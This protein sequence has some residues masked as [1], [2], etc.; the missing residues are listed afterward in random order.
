MEGRLVYANNNDNWEHQ[1]VTQN[2][3]VQPLLTD[4]YQITMAYA[5]WKS[6]KT[7]DTAVFDLFFRQNPFQGEFTIFAGLDECLKF[8]QNF[9]YSNSDIAYLKATLPPSIE[10]EFFVF[11]QRLNVNDVTVYAIEEGSVAFPKVPLMR[12]EGP[13][14]IVQLLETTLLT[15]VNYASLMATNAAR[16]RM[17]AGKNVSL[18][19]FGL[20]RAQG[21]DG[22][23]SASKYAYVGGFDGT[24]N[25]LAG[26]MY[27]IPVKGTHAHAYITSFSDIGDL[28]HKVAKTQKSNLIDDLS[29]MMSV[30]RIVHWTDLS[31]SDHMLVDRNTGQER[32]L[33]ALS[34]EWRGKI[35]GLLDTLVDAAS[36]G[37][38]AALI[39]YAIAFPDG[40]MALVDTYDVKKFNSGP[41]MDPTVGLTARSHD[42]LMSG[43]LNFCAVALALNE[44][45]Y[46]AV[47][48]RIDSGDLAYL[49][50]KARECFVKIG[51]KYNIPWFAQLQIVASNDINEETILSLNEQGHKID[52][53][54]IGTHLVTCQRQPAL[55]CVYKLVE[56]NGV[57]RIKLSQDVGKVTMPGRK[58][59]YRLYGADGH[60]LID[61]MQRSIE[62]PPQAGE[63]VLCRHPFQES[64][65]AYVIPT[66]VEALYKV[67][68]QNGKVCQPQPSLKEVRDRVRAS[69]Q[70]LR[71]DHKRNLNP[72]PYKVAVSDC[73]YNFIHDL[74][75]QNAPIGELS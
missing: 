60:A 4:L 13:L 42:L 46:R 69:L 9:H 22:G 33:L 61:L 54:G 25:V 15:L 52:C 16:Y 39:S 51:N 32:D 62:P 55:G 19:E 56:V 59:A 29:E 6:G 31:G 45:G 20:R 3:I 70:T 44:L 17:V 71:Q 65:R 14:I 53:F 24:S 21:P 11:L 8:L 47:G 27:N 23:L 75:L 57:P 36:D 35:A 7:G 40:F 49:S 66:S 18:L 12:V 68:W 74:W 26:K 48:I 43:L 5:Y 34:I 41:L 72:T 38:L 30:Q 1:D 28:Q 2:G 67:Y 37:E 58:D 63:R 50:N 10:E 73:L 64:K